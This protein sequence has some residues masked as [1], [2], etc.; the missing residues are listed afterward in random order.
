MRSGLRSGFVAPSQATPL[1][2]GMGITPSLP[3]PG[4]P[5]S[6][7]AMLAL[8]TGANNLQGFTVF[9]ESDALMI[10]E[11]DGDFV[12]QARAGDGTNPGGAI[13]FF[14]LGSHARI[15]VQYPKAITSQLAGGS[16]TQALYWDYTNQMLLTCPASLGDLPINVVV[17]RVNGNGD[18]Q[19]VA[20]GGNA[21][22][23]SG[24]AA[25]I[26]I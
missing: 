21:W 23:C 15:W 2:G 25:L 11:S 10:D 12:P 1:W 8:A 19:V 26:E 4:L 14:L 9:T 16:M 5:A 7:G 3:A 17:L 24:F 13:N 18:A 20:P 22:D 6:L